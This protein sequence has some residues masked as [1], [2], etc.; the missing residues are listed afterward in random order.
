MFLELW[1]VRGEYCRI[2]FV[3]SVIQSHVYVYVYVYM[4]MY[5]SQY[6]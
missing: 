6:G 1:S 3:S 5:M 2:L 4:Y